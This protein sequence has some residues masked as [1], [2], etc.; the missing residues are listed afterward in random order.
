MSWEPGRQEIL[1]ALAGG[2]LQQV[3]GGQAAGQGWLVDARQKCQ[4]ARLIA[5]ADPESAYVTAYDAARFAHLDLVQWVARDQGLSEMDAYQLLS[6]IVESPPA[7]SA[8]PT[9]PRWPKCAKT[10]SPT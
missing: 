2:G 10:G 8:T 9:T 6:Q 3:A 7:P 1:A 5:A 4:T